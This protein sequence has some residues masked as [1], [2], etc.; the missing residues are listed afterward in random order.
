VGNPVKS[1]SKLLPTK[2]F[3]WYDAKECFMTTLEVKTTVD[4][5]GTMVV[6]LPA[7]IVPGE[8]KV[9]LV[10]DKQESAPKAVLPPFP[11]IDLPIDVEKLPLTREELYGDDER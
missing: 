4:E 6:N 5:N 7:N 8:Y 9:L 2:L 1:R 11:V 10:F 3:V